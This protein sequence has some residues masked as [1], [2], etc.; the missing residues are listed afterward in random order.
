[1]NKKNFKNRPVLLGFSMLFAIAALLTV[2]PF[3]GAH[4]T[5]LLGYKAL[6]PFMPISTIIS[7]YFSVTLY[8]RLSHVKK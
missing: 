4:E 5:S 6:C 3:P 2:I 7:L 8:R 1:M